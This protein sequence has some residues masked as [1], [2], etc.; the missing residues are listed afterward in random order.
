[1]HL[2]VLVA[3]AALALSQPVQA[4]SSYDGMQ[5]RS[6]K[7]LSDSQVAD[8][9][10]GRGMGLALAGELNGYP[11]PSHVLE[12]A[13]KLGLSAEQK[14][15]V[16]QLFDSMKLEAVPL[17]TMLLAQ[18]TA[19]D[20]AFGSHSI[21]TESLKAAIEQIGVT[22]A[23]LRNAHLKYHLQT[24]Q[25]LSADQTKRYSSLRGYDSEVPAHRHQH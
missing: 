13:D 21:T 23:A 3:L 24:V 2:V 15:R 5:D 16:Q 8:L 10:A 12:L 17:G 19:L 20:K 1:M 14:N 25:I 6:I 18:E 7:A 4:Q 22:Q 11:G 9:E